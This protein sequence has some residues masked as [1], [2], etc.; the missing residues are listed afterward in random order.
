VKLTPL[1]IPTRN[2]AKL[3]AEAVHALL[4]ALTKY[5][6]GTFV[7]AHTT[8]LGE[9]FFDDYRSKINIPLEQVKK[10]RVKDVDR[11]IKFFGSLKN[12]RFMQ[13]RAKNKAHDE[14]ISHR[15]KAFEQTPVGRELI[16]QTKLLERRVK[17]GNPFASAQ[18]ENLRAISHIPQVK[19][20]EGRLTKK[21]YRA[22]GRHLSEINRFWKRQ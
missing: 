19:A 18:L 9:M 8:S 12:M 14:L 3:D 17:R 6:K 21:E 22:L 13:R 20:M 1:Q 5:R 11:A 10:M 16:R 15:L 2:L 7:S 4:D